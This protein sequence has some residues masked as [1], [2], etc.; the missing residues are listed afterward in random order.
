MARKKMSKKL[1]IVV[2]VLEG[3]V[4]GFES[5]LGNPAAII[6]TLHNMNV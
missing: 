3:I 4:G 6:L 2:L 1:A 5:S